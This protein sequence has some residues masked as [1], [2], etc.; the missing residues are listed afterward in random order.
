MRFDD[1]RKFGRVSW[2]AAE[3]TW[4]ATLRLGPEPIDPEFDVSHLQKLLSGRR[5]PIKSLLLDQTLISGLGNIYADEALFRAG[6]AP[7]R[8]AASL[9]EEEIEALWRSCRD[10]LLEGIAEQGTTLRD[11]VDGEGR[12]GRFQE[13]LKVYG[14]I[15]QPCVRCGRPLERVVLSGRSS[16]FCPHCQR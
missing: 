12:T 10:V 14:R 11:Y 2:F 4:N 6:I 15:G 3:S 9:S 8:P 1:Q 5:R 13:R 16:S 7:T